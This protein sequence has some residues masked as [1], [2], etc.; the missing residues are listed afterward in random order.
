MSWPDAK[1]DGFLLAEILRG[2]ASRD[3]LRPGVAEALARRAPPEPRAF[4]HALAP[5][6]RPAPPF[7]AFA[8]APDRVRTLLGRSG[9]PTRARYAPPAG[10]AETLRRLLTIEPSSS[11]EEEAVAALGEPS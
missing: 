6:V 5:T 9:P 8:E 2:R 10:L 11:P 4:I 3:R 1:L 7:E